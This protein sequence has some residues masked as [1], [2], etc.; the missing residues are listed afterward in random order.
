MSST[1]QIRTYE[2][3]T[4][5]QVLR[6]FRDEAEARAYVTTIRR[7]RFLTDAETA[8]LSIVRVVR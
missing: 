1:P 6:T 4:S 5:R 2:V 3:G 7:A 8:T